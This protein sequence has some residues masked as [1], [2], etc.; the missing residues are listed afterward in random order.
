MNSMI[1]SHSLPRLLAFIL[2]P[3]LLACAAPA[4]QNATVAAG[5]PEAAPAPAPE[6]AAATDFTDLLPNGQEPMPGVT[7]GGQPTREQL[8]EAAA[9][10]LETVINLRGEGE[11]DI[12]RADV[13]ALGMTYVALPIAGTEDLTAANAAALDAALAEAEGPVMVHCGSGNRVGAMFALRAHFVEG[14]DPEEALAL[15]KAAGLTRLEGAT[16]DALAAG[17]TDAP[18][19]D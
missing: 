6:V 16:R 14:A 18:P 5:E 1:E 19:T 11:S 15:G 7:T 3:A 2:L 13:E 12:G 9:R 10:G 17:A 8:A 4:E